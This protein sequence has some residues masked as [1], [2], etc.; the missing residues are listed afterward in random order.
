MF[1]S[2]G[3]QYGAHTHIE[4]MVLYAENA[5]GFQRV[6]RP[7]S[8]S[9]VRQDAEDFIV[10]EPVYGDHDPLCCPAGYEDTRY[11]FDTGSGSYVPIAT[12]PGTEQP[13]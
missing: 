1:S 10:N 13:S 11:R 8:G 7:V 6:G 3:S 4:Q 5:T 12:T 9:N 2:E